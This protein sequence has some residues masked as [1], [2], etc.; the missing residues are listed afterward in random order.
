MSR[1]A[2]GCSTSAKLPPD[3]FT[4]QPHQSAVKLI[5]RW[6]AK[7]GH[8]SNTPGKVI[9]N[10]NALVENLK[11]VV[12]PPSTGAGVTNQI[13]FAFSCNSTLPD[14][15]CDEQQYNTRKKIYEPCK[16]HHIDLHNTTWANY[17]KAIFQPLWNYLQHPKFQCHII[18][19]DNFKNKMQ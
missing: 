17:N 4:L 16:R 1:S 8:G 19:T 5:M 2:A 15:G 7:G 11:P 10:L 6:T 13:C 3:I 12:S 14:K 18:P 9:K